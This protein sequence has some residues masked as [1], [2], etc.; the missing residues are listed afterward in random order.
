MKAQTYLQIPTP[1]HEDWTK[2]SPNQQ[3]RHC[4]SCYKTVVDFEMMTDQQLLN[5]F[6]KTNDNICGRFNQNQL[7]RALQQTKVERKK[8]WQWLVASM[9]SFFFM[10]NRSNAQALQGKVAV[11]KPQCSAAFQLNVQPTKTVKPTE[12]KGSVSRVVYT[13]PTMAQENKKNKMGEISIGDTTKSINKIP[14]LIGSVTDEKGN[15]I[16]GAMVY[17]S[18]LHGT[19][20]HQTNDAGEYVF[21][22]TIQF[23]EAIQLKFSSIGYEDQIIPITFDESKLEL[24]VQLKEKPQQ[25]KEVIVVSSPVVRSSTISCTRF[26]G[27]AVSTISVNQIKSIDT[28]STLFKKIFKV[29]GFKIFPNP[30]SKGKAVNLTINEAGE[31]AVQLLDDESRLITMQQVTVYNKKEIKLFNIPSGISSG[32]Y[33]IRLVNKKNKKQFT[34]KLVAQ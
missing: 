23:G 13:K 6:A 20:I 30:A 17:T 19:A 33:Y 4:E 5:F 18:L 27:G 24:H 29:E 21:N 32:L 34:D 1:C 7:N 14:Q 31:Y 15:P 25:L 3:G 8:G 2:M 16:S 26:I 10:V 11:S 9:A 22:N 28:V 12:T